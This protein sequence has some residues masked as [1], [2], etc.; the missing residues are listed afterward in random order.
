MTSPVALAVLL[1][2]SLLLHGLGIAF[3]TVRGTVADSP[4]VTLGRFTFAAERGVDSPVQRAQFDLHIALIEE[5]QPAA[6]KLLAERRLRVQQDIEELLR[7][8]RGGDF[9]DPS[10][11][12]LKRQLQEQVNTT[13]GLRAVGSVI[14]TDLEVAYAGTA[15]RASERPLHPWREPGD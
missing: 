8:A 11:R 5:L 1:L 3:W 13:L 10:L 14:I 6:R 7:R 15:E 9:D 12:E 2:A 4:E